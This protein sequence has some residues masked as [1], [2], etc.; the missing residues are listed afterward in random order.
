MGVANSPIVNGNIRT[1]TFGNKIGL[2]ILP[3][4][5]NLQFS[6]KLHRQCH[7]NLSCQLCIGFFLNF[8][9]RFP[10]CLPVP[11]FRWCMI[12]QKNLPMHH[13][14]FASEIMGKSGFPIIEFLPRTICSSRYHRLAFTP[15]DYLNRTVINRHKH[16]HPFRKLSLQINKMPLPKYQTDIQ[17]KAD[18]IIAIERLLKGRTQQ[19]LCCYFAFFQCE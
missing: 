4:Y 9:N 18:I 3:N 5:R 11:I 17:T 15:S 1:H 8:C 2:H 7:L 16:H 10:K 14:A 6:G 12:G 19:H 13:T